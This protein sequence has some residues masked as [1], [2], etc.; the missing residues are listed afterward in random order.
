[1]LN[2]DLLEVLALNFNEEN[3]QLFILYPLIKI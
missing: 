1:M 2:K 3:I